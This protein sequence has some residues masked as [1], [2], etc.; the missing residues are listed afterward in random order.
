[1]AKQERYF[2]GP[3]LLSDIRETITRVDS[4]AP[5]TSGAR[6]DVRLQELQRPGLRLSRGTFTGAWAVGET[7]AVTIQG[8][9]NTVEVTNYCVPVD[10]G[11]AS[12]QSFNVVFASVMGTQTA[13]EVEHPQSTCTLVIGG[14]DLRD[15][16][17][18]DP[19]VIQLLGHGELGASECGL[20][21][22]SVTACSTA[23]AT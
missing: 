16:P 6:Q 9:E 11:T 5:K 22:F 8:S 12:T 19:A 1:M 17:D 4:I 10:V 15:L 13:V 18:Y 20:K 7:K 23:T 21:W 2:I 14:V 3:S